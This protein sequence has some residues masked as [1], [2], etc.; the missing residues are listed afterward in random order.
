MDKCKQAGFTLTELLVV[1]AIIVILASMLL[2][3]LNMVREKAKTMSCEVNLKQILYAFNFYMEDNKEWCSTLDHYSGCNW[4]GMYNQLG[5]IKTPK[6]FGCLSENA[7]PTSYN[8][9]QLHYGLNTSTFGLGSSSALIW[10]QIKR[11]MLNGFS[12]ATGLIVFTEGMRA[13]TRPGR[14]NHAYG[15]KVS[16]KAYPY[17]TSNDLTSPYLRHEKFRAAAAATF[18]G[19]VIKYTYTGTMSEHKRWSPR[20]NNYSW[21][22]YEK[23]TVTD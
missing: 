19:G 5:Y 2:P 9:S 13:G 14:V 1:I 6:V 15:I 20:Q 18:G 4:A 23:Y 7:K 21:T 17:E 8:S 22:F 11:P 10:R 16:G 3:T 12:T